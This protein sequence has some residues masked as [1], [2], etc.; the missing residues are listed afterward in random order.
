MGWEIPSDGQT[1][2]VK[3]VDFLKGIYFDS[4]LKYSCYRGHRPK[5]MML[6]WDNAKGFKILHSPDYCWF[7]N[8]TSGL[9]IKALS[10][11]IL[12]THFFFF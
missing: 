8:R 11:I 7:Q 12:F 6:G 10:A 1:L 9:E 5:E 4:L 2:L 3:G